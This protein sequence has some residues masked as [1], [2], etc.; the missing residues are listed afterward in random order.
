MDQPETLN[1]GFTIFLSKP[2][3]KP[4]REDGNLNGPVLTSINV[5]MRAGIKQHGHGGL[6]IPSHSL[7]LVTLPAVFRV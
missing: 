6:R 3:I 4:A 1:L 7:L 5:I 2:A